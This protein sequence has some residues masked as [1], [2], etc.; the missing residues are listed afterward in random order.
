MTEKQLKILYSAL[1]LFAKEGFNATS[2]SKVAKQAGVSEGLIFKHF[3][4]KS[5]LL[6]AV[7][8]EG[9]K[10]FR[11]VYGEIIFESDPAEVVK[12]TLI[13]PFLIP[14]D[15]YE[16]WRLQFKLKWELNLNSDTKLEP[17]LV[18][19]EKSFRQLGYDNP[20]MEAHALMYLIDGI[21]GAIL[22]GSSID[23]DEFRNFLIEKYNL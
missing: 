14:E 20:K 6:Q 2:T 5:G 7:L 18:K 10:R 16:F 23:K 12:K 19:L 4:N 13:M 3:E 17:L 21:G 15:D 8:D 9:E 11:S 1:D 22:K